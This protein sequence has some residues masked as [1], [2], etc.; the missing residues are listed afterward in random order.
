M[1]APGALDLLNFEGKG[2]PARKKRLKD[3]ICNWAESSAVFFTTFPY[4]LLANIFSPLHPPPSGVKFNNKLKFLFIAPCSGWVIPGPGGWTRL[5]W[6]KEE[7]RNAPER[8]R[9]HRL[10]VFKIC[11]WEKMEMKTKD[12]VLGPFMFAPKA[13]FCSSPP[14]AVVSILM[15]LNRATIIIVTNE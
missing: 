2:R 7:R 9:C 1:D 8:L 5:S 3:M 13:P 12:V 6:R 4:F 11:W 14:A 10:L 15:T